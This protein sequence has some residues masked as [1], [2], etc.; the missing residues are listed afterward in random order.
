M[1]D[2]VKGLAMGWY[3]MIVSLATEA[4]FEKPKYKIYSSV[5]LSSVSWN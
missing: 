5:H 2:N 3:F 1:T 4:D